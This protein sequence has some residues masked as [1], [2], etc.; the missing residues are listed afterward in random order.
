VVLVARISPASASDITRAP[1]TTAIPCDLPA[2]SAVWPVWIPAL[3]SIPSSRTAFTAATAHLIASIGRS[4][5][6]KKPSPAVS[7]SRPSNLRI[8]RR[9][10]R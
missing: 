2:R 1:I 8:C 4:K 9:I 3:I 5:A 6:T 7:C 10:S